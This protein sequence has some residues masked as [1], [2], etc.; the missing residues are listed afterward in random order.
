VVQGY[1]GGYTRV[2]AGQFVRITDI[3]GGQV[4]DLF[5][6]SA[7]DHMEFLSPSVTRLYNLTLFPTVGQAFYSTKDRPILIFVEDHSPGRHDMLMASCNRKMFEILG[8]TDHPNC[9]DNYFKAA[10]EAGI[11]HTTKPDP[12]NFFQ[13]TPVMPDGSIA[14]EATMSRPGDYVILKAE[15]GIILILTS[16]STEMINH[17]KSSPL[18]IDIFDEKPE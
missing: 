5:A 6:L 7:E 2:A 12:V 8:L 15:V 14:A 11:R 13:N 4:G 18:C 3:E 1:S 9:R 16:C 17:G 10:S